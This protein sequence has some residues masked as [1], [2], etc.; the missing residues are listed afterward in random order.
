MLRTSF[1]SYVWSNT[2][3]S[4]IP[5]IF[6][7]IGNKSSGTCR[8][9]IIC[10]L[11]IV[12]MYSHIQIVHTVWLIGIKSNG[13][14][15]DFIIFT[16]FVCSIMCYIHSSTKLILFPHWFGSLAVNAGEIIEIS[17]ISHQ[18]SAV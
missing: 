6:Q 4:T 18:L 11:H 13:N 2:N 1:V 15:R 5:P 3:I 12:S 17:I 7:L 10:I 16:C 8:N 14:Y 9:F